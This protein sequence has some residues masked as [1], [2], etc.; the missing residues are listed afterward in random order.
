M[1]TFVQIMKRHRW[2]VFLTQQAIMFAIGFAFLSLVRLL[3]GKTLHGGRDPL[4]LVDGAAFV[5]LAVTVIL[6]TRGLYYWVEGKDAPS[7]GLALSLRRFLLLLVGLLLGLAFNSWAWI[8]GLVS[9]TAM[10]RDQ[11]SLHFDSAG[12]TRVLL[13]GVFIGLANSLLE[14]ITSRAFP[15]M[16]W[17]HRSLAFRMFVPSI[18]FAAQHLIDEPF[19]FARFIYLVSLGVVF[20]A[21]YALT[22]NIWLGVGLH[23]GYLL[24]SISL[25]GL[26][27]MGAIVAV[28][29]QPILPVWALDLFLSTVAITV[30]VWLRYRERRLTFVSARAS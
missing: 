5:L 21:A 15:M 6:M 14:E 8:A 29:G 12:I 2:L 13:T 16:L 20:S 28:S 23:T 1:R 9:G 7:L 24:A 10:I 25:S 30:F 22:G 27:H 17:R 26:W 4:G 19:D 11:I 18:F 3:T